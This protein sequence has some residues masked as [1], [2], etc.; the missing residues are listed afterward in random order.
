[1]TSN[2]GSPHLIENASETGEIAESVRKKV[3]NELRV[4][5]RP[6]FLNRVDE[7]V[8]F[9]PLT[10]SEIKRIVELQLDLLRARLADRHIELELS[11]PRKSTSPARVTIGLWRT[12]T[13]ALPATPGETALSRKLLAGEIRDHSRVMVE[14]KKGELVFESTPLKKSTGKEE[15]R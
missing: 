2:I 12:T 11:M 15:A 9:K 10:L 5:F 1:M 6:G 4:H 8:L 14:L 7:I 13:Q 3:M